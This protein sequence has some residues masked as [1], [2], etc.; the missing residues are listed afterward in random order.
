[1]SK[2]DHSEKEEARADREKFVGQWEKGLR[3]RHIAHSLCYA[4]YNGLNRIVGLS[5]TVL[6]AL[7]STAVIVSL[8]S[9]DG[10]D[11]AFAGGFSVLAT[12]FAAANSFLKLGELAEKHARAVAGFGDLRRQLELSE[13]WEKEVDKGFLEKL[14]TQ[15]GNLEKI[16]P[17]I[18][19]NIYEKAMKMANTPA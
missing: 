4:R 8:K 1:M 3:I 14:I 19:N 5:S 15:W 7:V 12:L 17:A 11:K 18:P 9:G 6:A 10:T 13:G 16:S 2:S